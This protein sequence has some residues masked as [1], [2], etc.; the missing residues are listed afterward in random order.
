[1]RVFVTG[2]TGLI[3]RRLIKRLLERGDDV[4]ALTRRAGEARELLGPGV[5][6]V[7]GDP[8]Q[9]GAWMDAVAGCDAVLHLAGENIFN[10]RWKT[11]FKQLLW[12]SRVMST[13]NVVAALARQPRRADGSPK[14]LVNASAIGFYGPTGDE[15]LTENSS[16]G[17][18]FLA[19]L[20]GAWEEQ[21]AAAEKHGIRVAMVRVGVVLDK[22]GGALRKMLTPFKLFVGGKIGN[23]RQYMS[24]IHHADM[25]GLFLLALDHAEARGPVN[26]TAPHPVTNKE[27]SKALGRALHRPSFFRTPRIMLRLTLGEVANVIASGQRVLPARALA[28]GY[29]FQF[30]SLEGALADV[31]K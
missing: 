4:A 5:D 10:R 14:V 13:M 29:Q 19:Q 15:E 11:W 6:I 23:G 2:G 22:E 7:E 20:C 12:D 31:L 30:P 18:D 17:N 16:R 26:G 27:F 9:P 25:V 1:M 8:M 21:A 24:W 28:L 3:G